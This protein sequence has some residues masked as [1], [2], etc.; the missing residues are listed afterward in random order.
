MA[1]ISVQPA[2]GSAEALA[3]AVRAAIAGVDKDRPVSRVRTI[4]TVAFQA[5]A[6]PR[7]RAVL[8]GTFATL[9][10]VLAMVGVFGVLAYSVQQ[11]T[12]EFGVRM[13]M[14]ARVRDVLRLVL[15]GAAR[16]TVI[17]IVIG[18]AAAA[19]LSR[20]LATLVFPV[21]PL[22]PVTFTVVPLFLL[23]TAAIAVAAPAWRAARVDPV[24]AFRTE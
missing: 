23:V 5:N 19:A 21:A 11:R 13:A 1:S 9:A 20:F 3:P 8:V 16:L 18:L 14:G 2:S 4:D 7:F 12:R 15:T 24:V 10:L 22:D 6:R 17:G